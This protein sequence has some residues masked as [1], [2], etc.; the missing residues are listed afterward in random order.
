MIFEYKKRMAIFITI[1]I[2]FILFDRYLKI[3]ALNSG[4][5]Y[6]KLISDW[7]AFNFIRNYNIAFSLPVTGLK[8]IFI[9]ILIIIFLSYLLLFYLKKGEQLKFACIFFII[10]GA[11]SN[12]ADRIAY[13][14]VVDYFDIKY[15]TVF[16]FA[17][18][19]IVSGVAG[20]LIIYIGLDKKKEV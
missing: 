18:M 10:L 5:Q 19:M 2:F 15:F 7:A 17:D 12:L 3:L 14:Y 16:N 1:A 20:M 6:V 11:I 9:I 4:G 13:G 8:L